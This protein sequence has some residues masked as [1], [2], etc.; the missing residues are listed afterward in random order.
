MPIMLLTI[1]MLAEFLELPVATV[2]LLYRRELIVPATMQ[3]NLPYFDFQEVLTAKALRDLLREGLS[4]SVL[5]NRL[6]KIRR[7]FPDIERPLAQLAAI[8]EG[9]DILLR[10]GNRLVDHKKQT[11]FDFADS[12]FPPNEQEQDDSLEPLEC[13]DFAIHANSPS[14][15][16][17][18]EAALVL[19]GEGDL[20]GALA[21]YRAA[22]FVGGPDAETCFQMGGVL[23]RLGEHTAARERYYMAL[24]LDEEYVEARANLGCLLAESGDWELAISAF[25]G[26]LAY[27]PDYAE[28]HYHLGTILRQHGD[29]EEA[30]EHLQTFLKLQ[31]DGPLAEKAKQ[32]I[33]NE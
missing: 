3:S 30:R 11:R 10:K 25:Q 21:A 26:A 9:K 13:L 28:V 12:E 15:E 16:K 27:H 1:P 5:E 22:L 8:A 4:V 18:C 32:M 33:N 2:R 6:N 19:D 20:R 17:L 31:P 23:Y 29:K 7:M 24:E 14:A